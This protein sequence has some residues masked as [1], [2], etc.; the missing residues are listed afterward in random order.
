MPA[1]HKQAKSPLVFLITLAVLV[2]STLV[3]ASSYFLKPSIETELKNQLTKEILMLGLFNPSIKI[4]GRDVTLTGVVSKQSDV[5]K[6]EN[7]A[8]HV[9]GIR[10][11]S[12][13]LVV[14]P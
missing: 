4:S 1:P 7:I 5:M 3:V 13:Q 12:N 6:A 11:V 10:E 9:A 2:V 8:R 14:K